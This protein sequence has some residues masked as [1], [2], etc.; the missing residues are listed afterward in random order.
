MKIL[1][2]CDTVFGY[3]G[4]ERVL[5]VIA[6]TMAKA[7]DVTILSTDLRGDITMYDYDRSN[8]K[9]EYISYPETKGIAKTCCKGYSYI[10]KKVLPKCSI[11][12]EG[13]SRSFFL[14]NYRKALIEK[15]NDGKY[16]VVIG[17]HVFLALHLASVRKHL[18]AQKVIAWIHNSYEALFTKDNPYLP[19]LKHFFMYQM[20]KLDDVV[21]LSK[22]DVEKFR[23]ELN[24]K[25]INIYNPLTLKP[26]G[27]AS[28]GNKKFIGVGRFSHK[29]KGFDILLK[30]FAKYCQKHDDGWTLEIVGEGPE[31][32]MY[33]D[34]ITD[35]NIGHRVTISPFTN[36]IQKHYAA[37]SAYVLSSRW[38]GQPLVLLEALSHGL[39][40]VAS[41]IPIAKE[42][43]ENT[44]TSLL[45]KNED[46]D[47][48]VRKM[49]E[50]VYKSNW[51]EMSNQS[52]SYCNLFYIDYIITKWEEVMSCI[53][54]CKNL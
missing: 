27:R 13:Y 24:L 50:I 41:D 38:E 15:I 21:V 32:Q 6:Q 53:H 37:A 30:A 54:I 46:I 25:C 14:P 39:P 10:Y 17:V 26:Q 44:G 52:L 1:F 20:K 40:I 29:H 33:K 8:V 18:N 45:F 34:I 47:D 43:L 23:K 22:I 3:G 35:N 36:N 7:N 28:M 49:E 48:L 16:D 11:T 5:S 31:R 42:L 4:V 12:S 2:Y 51:Q 19:G 9:F